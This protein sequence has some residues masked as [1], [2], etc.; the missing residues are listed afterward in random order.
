MCMTMMLLLMI[1]ACMAMMTASLWRAQT[2][3]YE[4]DGK[5]YENPP[6]GPDH[7]LC[8]AD[9]MPAHMHGCIHV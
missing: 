4:I 1:N 8:G 9:P 2:T 5:E 3:Y 7:P 6:E